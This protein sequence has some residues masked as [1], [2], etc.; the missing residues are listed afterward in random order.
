MAKRKCTK[1][2]TTIDK[3]CTSNKVRVKRTPLKIWSE[4]KCSG[5]VSSYCT[6]SGTHRVNLVTNPMINHEWG[7]DREVLTT[8][9][10]YPWAFVTQIFHSGSQG[11]VATVQP[12]KWWLRLSQE[13][14]IKEILIGTTRSG[15]SYQ[16]RDIHSICKWCW[17]V[18]TYKWNV[19]NGKI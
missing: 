3:T 8:R 5:R 2:Q 10:T 1:G 17:N 9:G 14:P 13:E 7:K 19:H 11:L 12:Y 16:L 4:L 18:A 6:T 15:I